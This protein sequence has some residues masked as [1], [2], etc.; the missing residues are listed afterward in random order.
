MILQFLLIILAFSPGA[1]ISAWSSLFCGINV[2]SPAQLVSYTSS[3]VN[4]LLP[5]GSL[6]SGEQERVV[7][8]KTHTDTGTLVINSYQSNSV[9]V[10]GTASQLKLNP[11][12]Q[13]LRIFF[14]NVYIRHHLKAMKFSVH[15]TLTV[16]AVFSAQPP[17]NV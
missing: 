1:Q 12:Y 14:L 8:A 4:G 17:A 5:P 7:V 2:N 3:T 6:Y 11:H 15:S 16:P 9:S 13:T 10:A